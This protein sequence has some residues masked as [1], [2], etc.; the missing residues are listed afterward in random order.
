MPVDMEMNPKYEYYII[1]AVGNCLDSD[2]CQ[3]RIKDGDKLAVHQIPMEE[4]EI[5]CNVGKVV[6]FVLEN[7]Y[8]FYEAVNF[9]GW[10]FMGNKG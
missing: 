1:N 4:W 7:R 2:L 6:C 10:A 8:C 9:W 3:T 5:M